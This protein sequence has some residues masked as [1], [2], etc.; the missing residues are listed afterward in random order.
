MW[1]AK[2]FFFNST[3]ILYPLW[4]WHPFPVC[5][6]SSP[7]HQAI[8]GDQADVLQFS[9]ILTLP[10]ERVRFYGLRAQ[11][12]KTALHLRYQCR[13]C[14]WLVFRQRFPWLP[15]WL[16]LIFIASQ[17]TWETSL[18]SGLPVCYKEYEQIQISSQVKRHTGW[19]QEQR[20]FCPSGVWDLLWWRVQVFGSPA[21]K[22]ECSSLSRVWLVASP[23]TVARQA[24]LSVDFYSQEFWSRLPFPSPGDLS[25]SGTEPRSP[26][27][28]VDSLLSEPPGKPFCSLGALQTLSFWGFMEALLH[29]YR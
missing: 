18:L 16:Q 10:R 17:R 19:G 2:Y 9:L 22:W 11:S 3:N 13:P 28:Q 1:L 23:W 27:L 14:F 25:N 7:H 8:L 4:F 29:R 12:H 15:L 24:P 21:W 20:S 6:V 26:A 5:G